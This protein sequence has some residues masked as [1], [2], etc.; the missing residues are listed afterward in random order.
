MVLKK[1]DLCSIVKINFSNNTEKTLDYESTCAII[2]MFFGLLFNILSFYMGLRISKIA[3]MGVKL[4][5][6]L[7]GPYEQR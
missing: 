1:H 6:I 7:G 3:P 4:L 2:E 5:I